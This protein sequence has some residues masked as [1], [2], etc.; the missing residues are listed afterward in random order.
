MG[1]PIVL[2]DRWLISDDPVQWILQTRVGKGRTLKSGGID[3]GWRNRRFHTDRKTV[4]RDI[5][6]LIG[7]VSP[8]VLAAV[9]AL[10]EKH[11]GF[12]AHV[13]RN[14]AQYR[15]ENPRAGR[16]RTRPGDLRGVPVPGKGEE[17]ELGA[18]PVTEAA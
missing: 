16:G 12:V 15:R 17:D 5:R 9:E 18:A 6:E 4:L 14:M 1:L 2:S 3:D 11:P 8:E 7:E 13:E 10:P